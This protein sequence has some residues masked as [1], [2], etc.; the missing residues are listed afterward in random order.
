MLSNDAPR[1]NH[2]LQAAL[3]LV[4]ALGYIEQMKGSPAEDEDETDSETAGEIEAAALDYLNREGSDLEIGF[5]LNPQKL[6]NEVYHAG[7]QAYRQAEA[8]WMQR[9]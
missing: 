2:D 7:R 3:Y 9:N 5:V 6:H 4:F 1:M 8:L